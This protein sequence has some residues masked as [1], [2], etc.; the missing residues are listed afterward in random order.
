MW[1]ASYGSNILKERFLCYI[2]GGKPA[3][4]IK[5]NP[6][7]DNPSLPVEERNILIQNEIY[8]AKS[9]KLWHN[10]GVAFLKSD[11]TSHCKTLGRMYK[12]TEQQFYQIVEQENSN[13]NLKFNINKVIDKGTLTLSPQLWYGKILHLGNCEGSPIFTFTAPNENN[14]EI[15]PPHPSYLKTIMR[16]IQENYNYTEEQLCLHFNTLQGIKE[17]Y[18]AQ[19]ISKIINS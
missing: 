11:S 5:E 13:V 7:C 4:A 18:S 14:T 1:Y 3:G 6:G 15:N 16:G 19:D 17:S 2:L 9:S 12:I 10:G 8:F